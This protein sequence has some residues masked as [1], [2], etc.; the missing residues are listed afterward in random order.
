MTQRS[1]DLGHDIGGGWRVVTIFF[2]KLG[3]WK[4]G[5]NPDS[6]IAGQA[7]YLLTHIRGLLL[8]NFN[9]LM[10]NLSY[11]VHDRLDHKSST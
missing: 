8:T 5:S 9:E 1:L 2:N 4:A 11:D 6:L 7:L 10:W 3:V